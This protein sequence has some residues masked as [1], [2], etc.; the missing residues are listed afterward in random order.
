[1]NTLK[2]PRLDHLEAGFLRLPLVISARRLLR[3]GR[4]WRDIYRTLK[5]TST[6]VK[7]VNAVAHI[8]RDEDIT[9]EHL[10]VQ[11]F[12]CGQPAR[13]RF[14]EAEAAAVRAELLQTNQTAETGSLV[15]TTKRLIAR[16]Q[17]SPALSEFIGTRL[18]AGEAPL[19]DALLNQVRVSKLTTRAS[20]APRNAWLDAVQS[21]GSLQMKW[22][23]VTGGSRLKRVAEELTIDDGTM[24]F[25]CCVAIERP[26]DKCYD[27]FG[28]C[29]GR[30]QFIL[31]G[32]TRSYFIPGFA[33][34][35][36]PRS[37]YRA[38]DLLATWQTVFIEHGV[39][40]TIIMEKGVSKAALIAKA[41]KHLGVQLS[42]ANSPHQKVVEAIFN[43]LWTRLS[44]MPG[45]VGRFMGEEEETNALLT[46]CRNGHTDPRKH[47][48][49]LADV[50]KALREAI[51]D[52]NSHRV[53]SRQYGDW[54]PQEWF[55]REKGKILRP[56]NAA[57]AWM[58]APVISPSLLIRR[59]D[60]QTTFNVMPGYSMQFNFSAPW[61]HDYYGAR[62]H[63]H[64]NPHRPECEAMVVLAEPFHGEQ[65]GTVLGPAVQMNW[66]TRH[67]RRLLGIDET[68]DIGLLR[69][70][71]NAQA[72]RRSV[73][74]IKT[75]GSAG[76]QQ[77]EARN[78][79]GEGAVLERGRRSEGG[80][81]RSEGSADLRSPTDDLS[82]LQAPGRGVAAARHQARCA[83]ASEEDFDRQAERLARD[84]ARAARADNRRQQQHVLVEDE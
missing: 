17:L 77:H 80:S 82:A 51:A 43:N 19:T 50:L 38:E 22:D 13:L 49:M 5:V 71:M 2:T 61:F 69:T 58:F 1:M 72:L 59:M 78:G 55:E 4:P 33:H 70:R 3:E 6:L 54:V 42:H 40:P 21:P 57:D 56:L 81:L 84:E 52:W 75:D 37:S 18:A 7:W 39:P 45:Q 73:V 48:P 12:K 24:N 11:T 29:V 14:N 34:T 44:G 83:G 27:K 36:R 64:Y 30:W 63:L 76:A 60:I 28:V 26:G 46:S 8:E 67:N 47:F 79:V 25:P 41:M 9:A 16:G 68:E 66:H 20:R 23:D 65:S 62:V 10:A 35:A 31:P 32:D 74:A 53:V 15:E